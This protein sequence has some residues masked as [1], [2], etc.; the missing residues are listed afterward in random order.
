M[1]E[2]ESLLENLESFVKD[3]T[4]PVLE[5]LEEHGNERKIK[6]M[7]RTFEMDFVRKAS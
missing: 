6:S 3:L 1:E 2:L 4:K 7:L 5:R